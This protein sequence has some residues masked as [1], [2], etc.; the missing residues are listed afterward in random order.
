M[1]TQA[2]RHAR[3][4]EGPVCDGGRWNDTKCAYRKKSKLPQP[5]S[6]VDTMQGERYKR[7]CISI[8]QKQHAL[9]NAVIVT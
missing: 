9:H 8:L 7:H 6:M 4:T 2:S 3:H 1:A 5:K